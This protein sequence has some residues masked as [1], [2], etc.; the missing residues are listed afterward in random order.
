MFRRI[1]MN[2]A[3]ID[4]TGSGGGV[5]AVQSASPAA[6]APAA[7]VTVEAMLEAVKDPAMRD[8][9]FSAGRKQ[10]LFKDRP[11][12]PTGE[13]TTT[14]A[15]SAAEPSVAEIVQAEISRS[16]AFDRAL[17]FSGVELTPAQVGRIERAYASEKPQ[18]AAEWVSDFIA[19]MGL[20]KKAAAV[21]TPQPVIPAQPTQPAP[22]P[23][24]AAPSQ[25]VTS[26]GAPAAATENL[27]AIDFKTLSSSD[28]DALIRRIG[29]V[30]FN[31]RVNDYLR[32]VTLRR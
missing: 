12:K 16:R 8:A 21:T 20:G 19:D 6:P 29:K 23:V 5:A 26:R 1:L 18:H 4:T 3:D 14:P 13:P 31:K 2:A 28:R 7:P 25:S 22:A 27:D 30:E 9:F 24:P 32:G 17:L 10:G 15:Q 11:A